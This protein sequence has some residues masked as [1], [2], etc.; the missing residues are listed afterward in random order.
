[1]MCVTNLTRL[2]QRLELN[3]AA[4]KFTQCGHKLPVYLKE[5]EERVNY[6][7]HHVHAHSNVLGYMK[8]LVPKNITGPQSVK[9]K[10][11]REG[12][13]NSCNLAI[14]PRASFY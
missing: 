2:Q 14:S 1:M 5:I 11:Y 4:V 3:C 9:Q 10:M 8:Q 13:I 6:N 7:V 12:T